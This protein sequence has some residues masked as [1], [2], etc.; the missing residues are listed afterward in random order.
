MP[1]D[2]CMFLNVI[3]CVYHIFHSTELNATESKELEMKNNTGTFSLC[4]RRGRSDNENLCERRRGCLQV[5][6]AL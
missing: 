1:S 3:S 2:A 6:E 5:S 4:E